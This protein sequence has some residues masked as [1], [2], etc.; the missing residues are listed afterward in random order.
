[1]G[2]KMEEWSDMRLSYERDKVKEAR[3]WGPKI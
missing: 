3:G 2:K 1:M